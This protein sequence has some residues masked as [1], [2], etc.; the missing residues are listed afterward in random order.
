MWVPS[1]LCSSRR[2]SAYPLV[3][4]VTWVLVLLIP[5]P[6]I[7]TAA[8][9]SSL[10]VRLPIRCHYSASRSLPKS[11]SCIPPPSATPPPASRRPNPLQATHRTTKTRRGADGGLNTVHTISLS[12]LLPKKNGFFVS[13]YK[14]DTQVKPSQSKIKDGPVPFHL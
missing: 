6:L 3:A 12:S 1:L 7:R 9:R 10:L 14:P 4:T 13:F 11:F 8:Y 5:R 2:S